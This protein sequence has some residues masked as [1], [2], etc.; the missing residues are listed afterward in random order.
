MCPS[1]RRTASRFVRSVRITSTTPSTIVESTAASVTASNGGDGGQALMVFTP[2]HAQFVAAGGYSK[3]ET[4]AWLWEEGRMSLDDFSPECA[5]NVEE[6][7]RSVG[8]F[9][10][11]IVRLTRSPEDILI[12]VAGGPGSKSA[13]VPPWGG[14][15]RAITR[16]VL[17]R[18]P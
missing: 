16:P 13:F 3:A 4:K 2:E 6:W 9:E 17:Q 5:A 18:L 7:Q 1:A 8:A 12:F 15:T 14:S 11:G 10:N